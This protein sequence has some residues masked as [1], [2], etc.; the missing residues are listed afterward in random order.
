MGGQEQVRMKI[1]A[2]IAATLGILAISISALA[3]E[4]QRFRLL[5]ITETSKMIL[6]SEIPAKTKLVLDA[7][8][9]KIM[10]DGKPAEFQDLRLYTVIHVKFDPRKGSKDGINLDGVATEIKVSTP[11]NPK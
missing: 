8:S 3:V 1:G 11:E 2:R 7:A 6:V 4:A 9:A 5:S 10:V